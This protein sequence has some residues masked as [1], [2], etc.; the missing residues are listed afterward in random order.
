MPPKKNKRPGRPKGTL[1]TEYSLLDE[2]NKR[3]YHSAAV[4]IHR[5]QSPNV[6]LPETS[7][8]EAVTPP[9]T[10][11]QQGKRGRLCLGESAMTPCTLTR[12]VSAINSEK[13]AK[14]KLS[15]IRRQSVMA[16]WTKNACNADE[17]ELDDVDDTDNLDA[18]GDNSNNSSETGSLQ[19]SRLYEIHQILDDLL[20]K[21]PVDNLKCF[22]ICKKY[23]SS[24]QFPF[25]QRVRVN[26]PWTD[27]FAPA[28]L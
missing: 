28:T 15:R 19:K 5:G 23:F 12:R 3:L 18:P 14:D 9:S 11:P 2:E 21:S 24:T 16:R 25:P 17:N 22:L 6:V 26:S 13:R 20:L 1:T 4:R 10:H 7:P 27:D 8:V